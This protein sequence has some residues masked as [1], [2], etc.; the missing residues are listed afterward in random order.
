M[1]AS[2]AHATREPSI[3]H[4]QE[5]TRFDLRIQALTIMQQF[6][7]HQTHVIIKASTP[8]SEWA[9]SKVQH[10]PR[11]VQDSDIQS[12]LTTPHMQFEITRL[13]PKKAPQMPVGRASRDRLI[14]RETCSRLNCKVD[15]MQDY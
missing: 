1:Y 10:A 11:R 8:V 4:A 14:G 9:S 2:L 3:R 7:V 5:R 13:L 15:G 6:C 12:P